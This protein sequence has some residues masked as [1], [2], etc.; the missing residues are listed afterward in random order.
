MQIDAHAAAPR[1][2]ARDSLNAVLNAAERRVAQA[3]WVTRYWR[4]GAHAASVA[5]CDLA[6]R[7]T[8]NTVLR[9]GY[10]CA[11]SLFGAMRVHL[12]ELTHNTY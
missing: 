12:Y 11:T 2:H 9:G 7:F 4:T 1:Q 8:P 6:T 3:C 5:A 10:C